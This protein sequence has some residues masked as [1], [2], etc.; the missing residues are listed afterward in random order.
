MYVDRFLKSFVLINFNNMFQIA[1]EK[2]K[3][4]MWTQDGDPLQNSK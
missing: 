1:K 4:R 2:H 3:N